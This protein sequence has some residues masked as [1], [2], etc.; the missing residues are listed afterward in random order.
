MLEMCRRDQWDAGDLDWDQTPR[1]MDRDD[2]IAI[3]QYFTDMT[4]IELLAGALFR[5]QHRRVKDATLR[6]IF[7]TFVVDEERHSEVAS[8]L[9]R[10]YDVHH[11]RTYRQSPALTKFFPH[12]LRAVSLLADDVANAYILGGEL[13]LDIALLRSIDDFVD[14]GMSAQAMRLINRDESRHI[15]IDYHM[16]GYYASAGYVTGTESR[17]KPLGERAAGWWTFANVLF[18]GKP[19]FR[20]VFFAPMRRLDAAGTRMKEAFRRMEILTAKQAAAGSPFARFVKSAKDV[21]NHP[22]A[23][24]VFGGLAARALGMDR[25]FMTVLASE[26]DIARASAMTFDDLAREALGAKE[27]AAR[28]SRVES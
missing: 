2:E 21:Y 6:E 17:T 22:V 3:V 11:Y 27:T 15:A 23:G 16:A 19:F 9:A 14:D 26:A 10:F 5:E 1:S 7:A 4:G 28:R 20:D 25:E 24:R 8:R 18:Y 12:F 13:I